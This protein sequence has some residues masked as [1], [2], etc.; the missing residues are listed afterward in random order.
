LEVDSKKSRMDF[1]GWFTVCHDTLIS[2][3]RADAIINYVS[4]VDIVAAELVKEML[5]QQNCI[6][7]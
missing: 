2:L 6:L 7:A 4:K 1:Q 3:E 5:R